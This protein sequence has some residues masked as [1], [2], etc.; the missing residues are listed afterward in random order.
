MFSYSRCRLEEERLFRRY[1][2][3]EELLDGRLSASAR[4]KV[5]S[6]NI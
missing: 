5:E 2:I 6:G 3:E 4:G 1:V